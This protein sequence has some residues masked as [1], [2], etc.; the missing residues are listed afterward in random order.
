M[1]FSQCEAILIVAK[2]V[3]LTIVPVK[4][5]AD[6]DTRQLEMDIGL[7]VLEDWTFRH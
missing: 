2:V 3:R 7:N 1:V 4:P 5:A 6:I